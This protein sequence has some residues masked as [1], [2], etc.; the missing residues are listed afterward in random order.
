MHAASGLSSVYI[1]ENLKSFQKLVIQGSRKFRSP[2]KMRGEMWFQPVTS[3]HCCHQGSLIVLQFDLLG[4]NKKKTRSTCIDVMMI[5]SGT[6]WYWISIYTVYCMNRNWYIPRRLM[7]T[8]VHCVS[9]QIHIIFKA[10]TLIYS[11]WTVF[12]WIWCHSN[13]KCR[14]DIWSDDSATSR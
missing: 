10:H 7:F 14:L 1:S 12:I 8:R 6:W 13:Q 4:Q 9:H 2:Q 5:L 3:P 11:N